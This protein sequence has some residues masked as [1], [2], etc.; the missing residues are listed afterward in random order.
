M[1]KTPL[2]F[3]S[4]ENGKKSREKTQN[5]HIFLVTEQGLE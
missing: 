5:L 1:F 3:G 4:A 2:M